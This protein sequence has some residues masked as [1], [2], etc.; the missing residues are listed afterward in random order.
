MEHF[1]AVGPSVEVGLLYAEFPAWQDFFMKKRNF[2][3]K[4]GRK[5]Q[6]TAVRA[7]HKARVVVY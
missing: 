3:A 1:R 4:M 6:K 7:F 2:F 5:E